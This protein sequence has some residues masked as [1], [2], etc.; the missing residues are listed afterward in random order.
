MPDPDA[1]EPWFLCYG[2]DDGVIEETLDAFE[3][4]VRSVKPA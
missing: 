1:R 3:R 4:A 2:H